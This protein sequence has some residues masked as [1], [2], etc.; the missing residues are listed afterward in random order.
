MNVFWF[1]YCGFHQT[2]TTAAS[3]AW[4]GAL[5]KRLNLDLYCERRVCTQYKVVCSYIP[6]GHLY[7]VQTFAQRAT[8]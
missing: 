6:D 7:E 2:S 1:W 3:R 5:R 8:P 4:R